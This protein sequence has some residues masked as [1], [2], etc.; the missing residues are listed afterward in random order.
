MAG[1]G[2]AESPGSKGIANWHRVAE[3]GSNPDD[4]AAI[5][6]EGNPAP[7]LANALSSKMVF[8]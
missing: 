8:G 7:M 1:A 6:A 2:L 3:A 4:L 5:I